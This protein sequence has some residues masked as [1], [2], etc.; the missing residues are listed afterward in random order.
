MLRRILKFLFVGLLLI[1]FAY[2]M[3]SAWLEY[4]MAYKPKPLQFDLNNYINEN[5]LPKDTKRV[6]INYNFAGKQN[7]ISAFYLASLNDTLIVYLHGSG[8]SRLQLMPLAKAMANLGYGFLLI[9]WP[10]HGESNGG[11]SW[12]DQERFALDRIIRWARSSSKVRELK[13]VTF[14]FSMGAWIASSKIKLKIKNGIDVAVSVGLPITAEATFPG[15]PGFMGYL[16]SI[17]ARATS[18]F[19]GSK[20]W[21]KT[22]EQFLEDKTVPLLMI[23]GND[24]TVYKRYEKP[25]EKILKRQIG[26]RQLLL[27]PDIGHSEALTQ[28]LN[29]MYLE[30]I[31]EF[32][33]NH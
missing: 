21:I 10:G 33:R 25:I 1:T 17:P 28:I 31:D 11:I 9:D 27:I 7:F 24:D 3:R 4:T 2:S 20:Y 14:A 22:P 8:A 12:D 29:P 16:Q 32:I 19:F 15:V 30:K 6:T 26:S 18:I 23:Y 5:I 13:L